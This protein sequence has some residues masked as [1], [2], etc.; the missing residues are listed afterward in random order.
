MIQARSYQI[1]A[2]SAIYQY[3]QASQGNPVIAMPTGT[4]KSVVIALFLESIYKQY[5]NQ[6]ILILTHVKELIVQNYQ[7][8]KSLWLS[9][10]AGIYSSGLNKR[11]LHDPIT[12]AGIAS[13]AKKPELFGHVD[14]V[15]IDEA[16][17][18][19]TNETT[20]YQKFINALKLKN[21]YLKI[22]GLTA[23]PWRLG[24]GRII[25]PVKG[26][27]DQEIPSLF[28]DICFD[29]TGIHAFNRLIAEN[30]LAPLIPKSTTTRLDVDGVH[31]RGGEFIEKELQTAVDKNEITLAAIK[32]AMELGY[33]R[34]H[35]LVFATGI[36]HSIHVADALNDN[37]ISAIAIHSKLSDTERDAA[38][39]GFL[40]GKYRA[41]VNNNMLTTGFDFPA[42]DLILC[43]RPT[44]S[45]VLWV[46]MLGRGTRPAPGK[47]NCLVLDFAANT[48][49]LGPINDPVVPRRKGQKGGT[50]PV[51]E[52]PNCRTIVHASL[53]FCNGI[54]DN[55]NKC[56][57]EFVFETK[58]KFG[59]STDELIKG[60]LPVVEIFKVDHITYS[61]HEKIDR[62]PMLKVSYYC[63]YKMFNE[64]VCIEHTNFA[65]KKARDW[66]RTRSDAPL[67]LTVP[68]AL[69]MVDSLKT[70][71]HLRVWIN[72]KYPD[73]LAMCFDGTAFGTVEAGDS[74]EI[75][76]VQIANERKVLKKADIPE[77]LEDSDIPF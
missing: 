9:A 8:L 45:P 73:I 53:R 18:V 70:P 4:G 44:A 1:E 3:F 63:G 29:I 37:G 47:E 75:P 5:P 40:S 48:K 25:D 19:S 36:D 34:N 27:N 77:E 66:W 12:F 55:G 23:T 57:H 42:I 52:C 69:E 46:Q 58:L 22:V 39:K 62:P 61:K 35:W 15:I 43:L 71:T 67:P 38:I 68:T 24:H 64:Y 30:Y 2:V 10:P 7:K 13:V 54:L 49:R 28:S 33:E 20:M 17:L 65:G 41:A 60:D 26:E 59:A 6:R 72:K 76:S 16:H 56:N 32:E 14:L 21:P 51:K 31:M 11:E 50:A 74:F